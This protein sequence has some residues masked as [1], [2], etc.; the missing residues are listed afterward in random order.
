MANKF[1]NTQFNL[2][3]T[4]AKAVYTCPA[5]TVGLVKS[6]QCFNLTNFAM[7]FALVRTYTDILYTSPSH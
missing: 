1:I 6:I 7:G 4:N 3:T 5:E 2:N